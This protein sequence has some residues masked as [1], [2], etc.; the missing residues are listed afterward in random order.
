MQ[1]AKAKREIE[2]YRAALVLARDYLASIANRY[3]GI[4]EFDNAREA[5][6]EALK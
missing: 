5:I 2:K 1:R 4:T 3:E 6:D